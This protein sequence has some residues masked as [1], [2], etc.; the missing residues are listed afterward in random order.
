V[1]LD[2]YAAPPRLGLATL[3]VDLGQYA[4]ARDLLDEGMRLRPDVPGIAQAL[5][6]VLSA[7]P[8]DSVRD[9]ARALAIAEGV[10]AREPAGA[11]AA[12]TMAMALAEL[13][14]FEDAIR[15]Q[16]Q[17]IASADR[18]GMPT[19]SQRMK[20]NLMRFE[21]RVP[22]RTPWNGDAAFLTF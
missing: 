13:G 15:W 7:T 2:P 20:Q 14:R 10:T 8:V 12:E 21:R 22:A 11:E 4:A 16:R 5:S 3:M 9:G 1:E 18:S 19:V 6:R 17:A